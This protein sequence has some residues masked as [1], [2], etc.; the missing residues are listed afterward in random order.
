MLNYI[1]GHWERR[2]L[3]RTLGQADRSLPGHAVRGA[4]SP[5]TRTPWR[6]G[7]GEEKRRVGRRDLL[8]RGGCRVELGGGLFVLSE[9]DVDLRVGGNGDDYAAVGIEAHDLRVTRGADVLG[10]PLP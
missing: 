10:Q 2:L 3:N 8:N 5:Y 9:H 7:Q 1:L 6:S 4:R